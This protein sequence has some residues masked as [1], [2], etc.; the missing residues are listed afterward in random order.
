MRTSAL[1]VALVFSVVALAPPASA[2][3][4]H[5]AT[6]SA[7]DAA[8]QQKVSDTSTDR[9]IVLRL[10]ERSE[11]KDLAGEVGL[12]L[13]RAQDAIATLDGQELTELAAQA[14]QVEQSLAGGQSRITISTTLLIV[15]LLVLILLI[16]ALK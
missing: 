14:R 15:A 16:V 8:L 2:Q 6:Q 10:L 7:I 11:V 4:S 9:E 12:D 1:L 5:A 13:R 3:T